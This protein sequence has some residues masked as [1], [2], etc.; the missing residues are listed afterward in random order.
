MLILKHV[1]FGHFG[2]QMTDL[3]K[4]KVDQV[5][6]VYFSSREKKERDIFYA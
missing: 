5:L 4:V 3:L 2:Q 6:A 1:L